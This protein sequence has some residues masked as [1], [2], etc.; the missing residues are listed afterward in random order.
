MKPIRW[1]T[2]LLFA[3]LAGCTATTVDRSEEA[4]Q[5]TRQAQSALPGMSVEKAVEQVV[6]DLG[7]RITI[8]DGRWYVNRAIERDDA[9]VYK[10]GYAFKQGSRRAIF[11]WEYD[12]QK[13]RLVPV[14]DY[15]K[16][17]SLP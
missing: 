17:V 2:I 15:A 9:E 10:V 13:D 4:L 6:S 8:A 14:T 11:G 12:I 3:G 1:F 7:S 5:R 16:Q